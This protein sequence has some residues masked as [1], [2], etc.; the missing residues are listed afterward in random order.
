LKFHPLQ[1]E[2]LSS[3][4]QTSNAGENEREKE[5]CGGNTN[6]YNNMESNLYVP[7]KTKNR[8]TIISSYATPG[9]ISEGM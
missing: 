2:W 8:T 7:Q 5:P 3:R 4:T 1:S 6:Q 9:H